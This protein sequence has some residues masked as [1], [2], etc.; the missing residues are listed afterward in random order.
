MLFGLFETK[1]ERD[2]RLQK[3]H[4]EIMKKAKQE[5]KEGKA[6][7]EELEKKM[8]SKRCPLRRDLCSKDCVHFN[9]ATYSEA[10]VELSDIYHPH[11]YIRDMSLPTPPSCKLWR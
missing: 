11:I 9:C 4:G 1:K 3:E 8:L 6:K 10:K 7:A 5:E 2:A